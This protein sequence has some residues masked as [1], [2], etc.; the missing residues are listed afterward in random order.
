M[1][2]ATADIGLISSVQLNFTARKYHFS[3]SEYF[4]LQRLAAEDG[5]P[6]GTVKAMARDYLL[7][8]RRW[9]HASRFSYNIGVTVL[10][11]GV[12]A[13]LVPTAGIAHMDPLRAVAVALPVAASLVEAVLILREAIEHLRFG[14]NDEDPAG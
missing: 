8:Q 6:L 4:D 5:I 12:A 1:F 2:Q 7:K 14:Q 3:P 13:T 10:F 11:F 9:T